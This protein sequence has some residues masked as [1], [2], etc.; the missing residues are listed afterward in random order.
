MVNRVNV[1]EIHFLSHLCSLEGKKCDSKVHIFIAE[2]RK[3][4]QVKMLK[5]LTQKEVIQYV[6][7]KSLEINMQVVHPTLRRNKRAGRSPHLSLEI[8]LIC[9]VID[10]FARKK[11]KLTTD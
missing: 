11:V 2:G 7:R 10:P 6:N 9:H 1:Q 8:R 4:W 5:W 3:M